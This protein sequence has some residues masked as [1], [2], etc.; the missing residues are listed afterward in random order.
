MVAFEFRQSADEAARPTLDAIE[1]NA[2]PTSLTMEPKRF[3]VGVRVRDQGRLE[4][5]IGRSEE[6]TGEL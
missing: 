6:R 4:E 3:R 1:A 2:I 5:W